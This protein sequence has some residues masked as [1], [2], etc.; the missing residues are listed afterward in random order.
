MLHDDFYGTSESP[1]STVLQTLLTRHAQEFLPGICPK[2]KPPH[3]QQE[4]APASWSPAAPQLQNSRGQKERL[5]PVL[6]LEPWPS[7]ICLHP[8]LRPL[9]AASLRRAGTSPEEHSGNLLEHF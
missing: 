3:S 6:S 2:Q 9:Q 5:A 4:A 7:L 8:S 1:V